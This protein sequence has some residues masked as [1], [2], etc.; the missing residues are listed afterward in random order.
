[1]IQ[2]K[3]SFSDK[4]GKIR[5]K[6]Q[7]FASIVNKFKLANKNEENNEIGSNLNENNKG[8]NKGNISNDEIEKSKIN[9]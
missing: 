8:E 5:A 6:S 1:M 4:K 7:D 3:P 9:N 2:P